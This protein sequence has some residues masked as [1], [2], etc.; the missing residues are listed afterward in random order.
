MIVPNIRAQWVKAVA[1]GALMAVGLLTECVF[2]TPLELF[3]QKLEVSCGSEGD[4]RRALRSGHT[5]GSY[6]GISLRGEGRSSGSLTVG[7]GRLTV[8]AEGAVLR[9]VYLSWDS[10]TYPEQLSSS[11]LGCFDLQQDGAS[12]IILQDFEVEGDCG[13]AKDEGSCSVLV[14]ARV[15]DAS[16]PTGQTYSASL[17]KIP[18]KKEKGDLLIPFSNLMRKGPR[19][20]AR[21]SCAGAMTFFV[22]PIGYSQFDFSVGLIY[23]NSQHGLTPVPTMALPPTPKPVASSIPIAVST[24]PQSTSP[25]P[26]SVATPAAARTVLPIGTPSVSNTKVGVPV[27][28]SLKSSPAVP[29]V[30]PRVP[31]VKVPALSSPTGEPAV[32]AAAPMPLANEEEAVYGE[33]I[34]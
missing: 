18:D 34:R 28:Q 10:D 32:K 27:P 25:S 31:A 11:G 3:D 16:D 6:V 15:Y 24:P 30:T 33:V 20:S 13:V 14:E 26:G 5:L 12:A 4:C 2:A 9:G 22:Q 7:K 17:L 21:L 19:G 29:S 23:T 8:K 1:F